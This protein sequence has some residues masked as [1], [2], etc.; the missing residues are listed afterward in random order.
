MH[1]IL[2]NTRTDAIL[3]GQDTYTTFQIFGICKKKNV[4]KENECFNLERMHDQIKTDSEDKKAVHFEVFI[5]QRTV[6]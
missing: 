3:K 2:S 6:K 5:H 1:S 4:I